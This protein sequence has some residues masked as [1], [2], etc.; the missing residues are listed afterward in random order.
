[1]FLKIR[2]K[3]LFIISILI[4]F[5]VLIANYYSKNKNVEFK[6]AFNPI[7]SNKAKTLGV[8]IEHNQLN[9]EKI[10][11]KADEMI[12]DEKK[13]IIKFINPKTT[14]IKNNQKTEITSMMALVKN[15][16]NEFFLENKVRISNLKKNF[17]LKANNL[18]GY[19]NSGKM[20]TKDNVDIQVQNISIEGSGLHLK[21][22]G[23]YIKIYG[24]AKLSI[25]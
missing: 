19:F 7:I 5:A 10:E 17:F 25:N 6:K 20:D 18:K 3:S 1:M 8:K 11:I 14:I 9:G 12:E 23:D 13:K 16:N 2:F 15:N 24:K 22:F 21:N 4:I